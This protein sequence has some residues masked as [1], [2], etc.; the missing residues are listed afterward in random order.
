MT[1]IQDT[2]FFHRVEDIEIIE[3]SSSRLQ[4]LFVA[5]GTGEIAVYLRELI[6]YGYN[7]PGVDL[8]G[9]N[10]PDDLDPDDDGDGVID[11]W[12][13]DFGCDA[14]EET[15]CSRYPDL[16]KIRSIEITI[17]K[18]FVVRDQITLP[19]EDSSN[20]RNLSRNAIARDQV[21]SASETQLLQM[22]RKNMDHGDI[23][24]QLKDS[25]EISSGELGEAVAECS[26]VSGMELVRDGDSTTQITISITTTFQYSTMVTLPL[27][28]SL[29]EQT[30]PTDGSIVWLAPAHPISLT[31]SG[32]G[33]KIENSPWW[34]DGETTASIT[35]NRSR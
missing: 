6:P 13:D 11:D 17:G 28:L 30:L 3:D 14:P 26:V 21:V 7:S 22:L 19:T 31:F 8:D 27:D 1:F 23:I 9:D 35:I 5:A 10:V 15:P 12:D 34:N 4:S 24:D 20:I 33:I 32:D 18:E 2:T 29:R 25:I 16:E